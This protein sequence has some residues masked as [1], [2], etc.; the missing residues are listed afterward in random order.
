MRPLKETWGLTFEEL[1]EPFLAGQFDNVVYNTA[2]PAS[3]SCMWTFV[4]EH[5][6][7]QESQKNEEACQKAQQVAAEKMKAACSAEAQ[8]RDDKRAAA[9]DAWC[10]CV[11]AHHAACVSFLPNPKGSPTALPTFGCYVQPGQSALVAGTLSPPRA[12][13]APDSCTC[14]PPKEI[15][16]APNEV[17]ED[18]PSTRTLP[19]GPA[20]KGSL[21]SAAGNVSELDDTGLWVYAGL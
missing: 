4:R 2:N 11:L 10:A 17:A 8:C 12:Q 19:P 7:A 14:T 5:L 20:S 13:H 6:A 21:T 18:S 15:P 16:L 1:Q 9:E 3:S